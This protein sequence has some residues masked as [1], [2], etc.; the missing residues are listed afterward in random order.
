MTPISRKPITC[1]LCNRVAGSIA[2]NVTSPVKSLD[3]EM[4][5]EVATPGHLGGRKWSCRECNAVVAE[6]IGDSDNWRVHTS[7]GW[8]HP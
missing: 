3:V 7:R 8:L 2:G 4:D 1:P 5:G 6:I